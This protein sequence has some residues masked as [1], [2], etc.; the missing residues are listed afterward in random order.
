MNLKARTLDLVEQRDFHELAILVNNNKR[1]VKYIYS[2]LYEPNASNKWNGIDAF[3]YLAKELGESDTEFFRE[4]LRRFIW[5]MNE[6]GGNSNWS[7]P[8]AIGE[9]VYNQPGLFG[10]LAPVMITAAIDEKIFQKGMLWAIA[11]F[12]E[13]IPNEVIKF[14]NEI[15]EF[16]H[17]DNPEI[18]GLAARALGNSGIKKAGPILQ[19]MVKNDKLIEIYIDGKKHVLTIGQI[20]IEAL[21]KLEKTKV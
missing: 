11:R 6:E 15:I 7:A 13:V 21:V 5:M 16:L 20:A 10:Y 17:C 2:V 19:T 4:I 8:E 9:I 1:A 18:K 3:G 12:G 14:E